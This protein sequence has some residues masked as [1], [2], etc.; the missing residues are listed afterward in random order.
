MKRSSYIHITIDTHPYICYSH[1]SLDVTFITW[2]WPEAKKARV[3]ILLQTFPFC[4]KF[5]LPSPF[6]RYDQIQVEKEAYF[7]QWDGNALT[8]QDW[9]NFPLLHFAIDIVFL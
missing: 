7:P 3:L 9:R 1:V 2:P 5:P 8:K 4:P 6:Y